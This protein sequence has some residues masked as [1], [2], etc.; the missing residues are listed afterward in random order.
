MKMDFS[1]VQPSDGRCGGILMMWKREVKIVQIYAEPN[2]ID[3]R[4]EE[5]ENKIWRFTGMCGEF[6]WADKYRTW[7]R[8]KSVYQQN[9]LPWLVMGDLNEIL[10]AHEK[11]GGNVRPERFRQAFH[12]ALD[13]CRLDDVGFVGDPFTWHRGQMRERLDRGLANE[14]WRLMHA[15]ATVL[16]LQYNHSDHRPL[17][18]DREYYVASSILPFGKQN[19]FEAK[20]LKEE[21]FREVV[22]EEWNAAAGDG[23]EIDVLTR[24]KNM[25]AELYAWDAHVLKQPRKKLR[26]AQRELETVMH[27]P[28]VD[29]NEERKNEL[30]CMIEKLLAQEEIKWCQRSRANLLQNGDKNTSFF[31]SFASTR[32]KRNFIKQLKDPAGQMVEGTNN[33]NPIILQF[34]TNLF[35]SENN[36]IDSDFLDKIV[37][38][39]TGEMNENLIAPFTMEDVKKA[40]FQ[41]GDL[42]APGPDGLHAIFYKKF[43]NL[44]GDDITSAV[45]KAI[46]ERIIPPGWNETRVVLIPKVEN[47]EEV[48]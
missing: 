23:T 1:I 46:N 18:L 10:Y 4:V 14:E 43:W 41:I 27:G 13:N 20:W 6:K 30:A 39:V 15:H 2:Y 25:H 17:L 22:E 29:L 11:E 8:M 42:K 21:G 38:T 5:G 31:H 12:D 47:P 7:D 35:S 9:S 24:L 33:L 34:F 48:S 36:V 19:S 32:K 37:P 26:K 45:L 44:V 40:V 3:V 16:H 28:V